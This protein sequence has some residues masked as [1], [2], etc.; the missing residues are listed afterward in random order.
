MKTAADALA[1]LEVAVADRGADYTYQKNPGPIPRSKEGMVCYYA[2]VDCPGCIVAHV[3]HQWGVS[4][5]TLSK[6]DGVGT[7]S[8]I[9]AFHL[10]PVPMTPE[11]VA[12]LRTAQYHQ[13]IYETWGDAVKAARRVA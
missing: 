12:V 13:D 8:D 11:A 2:H 6:L 7:I 9:A 5:A 4:L 3:L 10:L 1:A